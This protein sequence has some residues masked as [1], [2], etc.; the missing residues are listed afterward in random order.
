MENYNLLNGI[1]HHELNNY[2]DQTAKILDI[3]NIFR[4]SNINKYFNQIEFQY[5]KVRFNEK[6]RDHISK[7]NYIDLVWTLKS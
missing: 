3:D 2:S 7:S 4:K 1:K 5:S 6:F